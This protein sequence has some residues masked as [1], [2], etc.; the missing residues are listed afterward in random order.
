ME[1]Y[2]FSGLVRWADRWADWWAGRLIVSPRFSP[3]F[4]GCPAR[5]PIGGP[6]AFLGVS[7]LTLSSP[8]GPID[9]LRRALCFPGIFCSFQA[10]RG[11]ARCVGRC[12]PLKSAY[13]TKGLSSGK[14]MGDETKFSPV[15]GFVHWFLGPILPPK[16]CAA[17]RADLRPRQKLEQCGGAPI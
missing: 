14:S 3:C 16:H 10:N 11:A 15:A 9:G 7:S 5:G 13:N 2:V 1:I 4:F 12:A 6:I 8:G 17:R